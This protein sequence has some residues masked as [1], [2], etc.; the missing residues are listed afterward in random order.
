MTLFLGLS[1]EFD[2][3]GK[4]KVLKE[5]KEINIQP[6]TVNY[7]TSHKDTTIQDNY[8]GKIV[9]DPYRWLED[10]HSEA[11]KDWVARQNKT[12]ADYLSQIPYRG[13]IKKRLEE[14]WNY[15]RFGIPMQE[16]GR[17]FYF[18]NDGL[19]NQSVLYAQETLDGTPMLVLDPNR[20]SGDG[21]SSLGGMA[22]S[23][24]GKYLAYEVSEGGSDWRT[25]YIKD[26]EANHTLSDK[27]EW[28]KFSPISWKD[29][30]FFYSRYP[31]PEEN[32]ELSGRNEFHSVYY[33][34]LGTPQSEDQIVFADRSKPNYGFYAQT[35]EDEKFLTVSAWESTSGN[36]FY[37][38]D[39]SSPENDI[40][41]IVETLNNDFSLIGHH[42]ERLLVRTNY[43]ADNYRLIAIH[44]KHPDETYW[45]EILPE[46]KDLLQGVQIIGG[47]IVASYLH[48]AYSQ[49]K[50]FDKSGK[51]I[52]DLDLP[53]IGTINGINGKEDSNQAFYGFTSYTQ[54]NT[55]YSLDMTTLESKVFKTPNTKFDPSNYT[56]DQVWFESTDGTKIPMF[57]TYKKG[58]KMDGSAPTLLYGYGGFNVSL[59]PGFSI[60]RSVFLEYGGIYAV[61]NIR[62][63][64]EFGKKWHKAGTLDQKQNVFNDFQSAAEYLIA[65][66]YTTKDKLAI[67]GRSNGGLLVGAC[68]TQRPD[69]FKVALP[70]VGVLD[71]LRYDKFTIGRAWATD[72]GLSENA[73]DFDY[74]MA[75][76]PLHNVE[77]TAY[78]ATLISTADHDDRVV[79][80]HSFKFA[81]T[82]QEHHKGDNP[83]LIRIETSAG[84]GAGK[85]T[86]KQI[87][88]AADMLSFMFYN[89]EHQ[90]PE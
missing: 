53:G 80:A 43:K 77:A 87:D 90:L 69:L 66:G 56:T 57:L 54:P 4:P 73:K 50:V 10:D 60:Q 32:M 1:C 68:M 48:N 49:V 39:I 71:M 64:G 63:G 41:A 31:E 2:P 37:F 44:S 33:H 70:G 38:Q 83:V 52:S 18:K 20:L 89:L 59:T 75:Y 34:K 23:K 22:F 24:N 9:A 7:P 46:S 79:P 84:H 81:A 36:A 47:K 11:T 86:S 28:V 26:L 65:Q 55:I 8:H 88:E 58:T 35:T 16:G 29:D 6:I 61:A 62:G 85:P 42:N 15:E 14:V 40:T 17:F 67:D 21:T 76:S 12:T 13:Q 72:Y 30:G 74:L 19:Q 3:N 27:L 5:T 51:F 25:I 45:E 82:L 78:P